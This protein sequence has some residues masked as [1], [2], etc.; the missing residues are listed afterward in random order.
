MRTD[1]ALVD[2]NGRSLGT[3][4]LV[5]DQKYQIAVL[6]DFCN[7]CGNCVTVCPTSGVPY[8]DKPRL[9]LNR[10]EFEA[11]ADNAFMLFE[12]G[13]IEGRF[14]G[15]TH[16]LRVNGA[17]EYT[18]PD[19][20]RLDP[21]AAMYAVLAGIGGSMSHLPRMPI[22]AAAGTFVADPQV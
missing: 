20:T 21:A 6:T 1:L 8:Q 5:V 9:Y 19:E 14:G 3:T 13:S 18:G 4:P 10:D 12:D 15:D 11:E 2:A 17:V 22:G 7:E 16:R